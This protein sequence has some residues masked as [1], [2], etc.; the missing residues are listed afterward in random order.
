MMPSDLK[1]LE[2]ACAA[3]TT[4]TQCHGEKGS[5]LDP[6]AAELG[7]QG[8]GKRDHLL[9]VVTVVINGT[10]VRASVDSGAS[11]SFV[12]DEL[13]LRPPL[14]FV[15][16]YSSLELA[17]GETIVS[18]GMAPRVLVSIGDVQ[19]R[20]NLTSIPLMDGIS[21]ILGKD[22]LDTLNPLIDWR[23][24]TVYLRVGDKLHKVQGHGSSEAQPS[25]IKDKGLSGL[26]DAFGL[27][28]KGASTDLVFGKWGEAYSKLASPQFWEYCAAKTT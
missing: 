22:W 15:G 20:V 21:V 10:P 14:S 4:Q 1:D 12:S 3:V 13:K 16:A 27:W 9:L 6:I 5:E 7:T 25:G 19:C 24:N 8:A 28:K 26:R 18:T 2:E 17:N 23:S 11:R